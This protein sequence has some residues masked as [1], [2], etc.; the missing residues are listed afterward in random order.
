MLQ[1]LNQRQNKQRLV[2]IDLFRGISAYAVVLIHVGTLMIYSGLPTN[3][4]TNA[5][6]EISRF[7]VPFFL[8]SSFYLM[9]Q[10]LYTTEQKTSVVSLFKSRSQ[11]LL[12][13]YFLWSLIYLCLRILKTLSES[14]NLKD[15]FQ[16][17]V[18][19]LFLGGASIHLYF[20]PMLFTGSFLIILAEILVS[21][22]IKLKTLLV[23]SIISI[24]FY[25]LQIY[26]GNDFKFYTD[27]GVNCLAVTNACS[28][29]F[30]S[31]ENPIFPNYDH[32][33]WRL[34][35]VAIAWLIKCLPYTLLAMVI[36]HPR[37]KKLTKHLNINHAISL[38]SLALI[39]TALWL[40]NLYQITYFPQSL[41]ELGTAF[42]LLICGIALS[43]KIP[44]SPYI[45][46]LGI[47][48]FGIYLIHYLILLI[49]IN[50]LVKIIPNI[51]MLP[52]VITMLLI[53]AV[54]FLT[55]W[56]IVARLMK[57]KVIS[58]NLFSA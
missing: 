39:I 20:L 33:I 27:F 55:S 34:L 21:R 16:D 11:R 31:I 51:K 42:S 15:L 18:L 30:K 47:S 4:L 38:L 1:S 24:V 13:P 37:I 8:A 40:L 10:K 19:L 28:I 5:V 54:G 14:G 23:L 35:F 25:E 48:S 9:T 17:P 41:Y 56:L 29:A 7:A 44:K 43:N 6:I 45:E 3:N 50:L 12:I 52:P 36:N 46:N 53:S 58:K 22:Q 26:S 32:Q 49:Y 57:I 2:G